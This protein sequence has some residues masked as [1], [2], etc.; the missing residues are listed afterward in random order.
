MRF[1]VEFGGTEQSM[2]AALAGSGSAITADFESATK[3]IVSEANEHYKGEYT[4]TPQTETQTM[5]TQNKIMDQDVT[6][7]A[8][9]YYETGNVQGGNTVYIGSDIKY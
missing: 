4:V 7:K 3:I 8:I 9:P 2:E 5:Q 6:I 1:A